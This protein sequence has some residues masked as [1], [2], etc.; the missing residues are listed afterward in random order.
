MIKEKELKLLVSLSKYSNVNFWTYK[1]GLLTQ[2]YPNESVTKTVSPFLK[3]IEIEEVKS[4]KR[5]LLLMN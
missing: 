2:M 4:Y 5:Y 1:D 3:H